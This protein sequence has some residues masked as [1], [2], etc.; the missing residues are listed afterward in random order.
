MKIPVIELVDYNVLLSLLEYFIAYFKDKNI[1]NKKM[2]IVQSFSDKHISYISPALSIELL[3]RK[4][5]TLGFGNYV[6][7][8]EEQDKTLEIEGLMLEYRVQLNVY[9]NTR[10][11]VH[12]WCS[13]IDDALFNN[14]DGIPLNTYND[15]GTIKQNDIGK[16]KYNLDDI[17]NNNLAP[18]VISSDFHTL[19]EIKMNIIQQYTIAYDYMEISNIIGNLK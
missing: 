7:V 4:N 16:I 15:N 12:K 13:I 1:H 19:Y 5:R 18:N 8:I 9:S 6:D 14:E 11:E 10:G 3:Y 2:N 17:K